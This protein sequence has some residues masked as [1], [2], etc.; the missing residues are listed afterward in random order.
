MS[1]LGGSLSQLVEFR[2]YLEKSWTI[3]K[4]RGAVRAS[5]L[6]GS[7]GRGGRRQTERER[8]NG[9]FLVCD[10]ALS[11]FPHRGRCPKAKTMSKTVFRCVL[12][13]LYE[14]LSVHRSV[15]WSI[16]EHESSNYSRIA[17]GQ[18][19]PK[20]CLLISF[21]FGDDIKRRVLGPLF[22]TKI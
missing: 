8:Q 15:H 10:G 13:S 4:G 9:A 14:G 2:S 22:P 1:H 19:N 5:E 21:N 12:L 18:R 3:W 17:H 20:P 6:D 16:R 7:P 11:H